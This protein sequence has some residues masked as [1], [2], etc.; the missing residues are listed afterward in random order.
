[1]T[2]GETV[3]AALVARHYEQGGIGDILDVVGHH[4]EGFLW[5]AASG[6]ELPT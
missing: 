2:V 5:E 4:R 3:V 6:V 1:M